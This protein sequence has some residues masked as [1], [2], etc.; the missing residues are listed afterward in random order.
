MLKRILVAE[1]QADMCQFIKEALERSLECEVDTV[2][3]GEAALRLLKQKPYDLLITDFK[4]PKLDGIE[5]VRIMRR[6][7]I[8][9]LPVLLQTGEALPPLKDKI[10]EFDNIYLFQKPFT[11]VLLAETVKKVLNI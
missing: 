11:V 5:L 10:N 7:L 1:D 8:N 2:F 3:D 9:N 6:E 4:M